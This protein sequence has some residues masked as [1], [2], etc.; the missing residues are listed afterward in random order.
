MGVGALT[1]PIILGSEW[2]HNL[3]HAAAAK[4]VGKPIDAIRVV[5]GMPLLVYYDIN[6][7][8]VTP[9]QHIIRALG[10]PLINLFF[11]PFIWLARLFAPKD[12]VARETLDVAAAANIFLP[13]V[14]LFPVPYIDGGPLLKWTLVERGRTVEEADEV[15]KDVNKVFGVVMAGASGAAFK[16]KKNLFGVFWVALAVSALAIGFGWLKEQ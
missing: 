4:Y 8:E 10:G 5:W 1:M 9:R 13:T 15:V 3:A 16:R 11:L 2:C 14:G 6:D 7:A 12:S